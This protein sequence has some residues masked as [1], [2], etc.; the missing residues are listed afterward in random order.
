MLTF[1]RLSVPLPTVPTCDMLNEMRHNFE[2]FQQILSLDVL[3][4]FQSWKQRR[5]ESLL[6]AVRNPQ[7][8]DMVA[9]MELIPV[10]SL[11]TYYNV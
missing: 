9:L 7:P 4:L 1:P 10:I 3:P 2:V 6:P 8:E 5:I 11:E